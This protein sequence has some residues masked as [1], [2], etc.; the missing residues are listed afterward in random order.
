MKDINENTGTGFELP[1]SEQEIRKESILDK[2]RSEAEVAEDWQKNGDEPDKCLKAAF[3]KWLQTVSFGTVSEPKP[4]VTID[5]CVSSDQR[6]MEEKITVCS[7][8]KWMI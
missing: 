6:R 3:D 5:G 7:G 2:E 4:N 1:E 8:C